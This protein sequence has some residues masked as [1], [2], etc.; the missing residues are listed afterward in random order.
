M[1]NNHHKRAAGG[2]LSILECSTR[3]C[4]SQKYARVF[5]SLPSDA[6]VVMRASVLGRHGT[7]LVC[8]A[9]EVISGQSRMKTDHASLLLVIICGQVCLPLE[10]SSA[11]ALSCQGALAAMCLCD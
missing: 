6:C 1:T 2:L 5:G 10:T 8:T 4:S 3:P 7:V 11:T 9:L